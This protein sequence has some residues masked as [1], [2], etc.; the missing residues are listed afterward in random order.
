M[1]GLKVYASTLD[2][3]LDSFY[4][5]IYL[6]ALLGPG[7]SLLVCLGFL[8]MSPRGPPVSNSSLLGLQILFYPGS[9]GSRL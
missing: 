7:S 5:F 4:V 2:P 1:P 8:A 9:G 6:D 3:A